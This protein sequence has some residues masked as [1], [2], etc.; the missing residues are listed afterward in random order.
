MRAGVA[1]S[2]AAERSVAIFVE[3]LRQNLERAEYSSRTIFISVA[4]A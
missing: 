1:P 2:A 3:I 4:F